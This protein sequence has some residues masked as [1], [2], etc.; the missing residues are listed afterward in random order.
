MI[1]K[2]LGKA[3]INLET[4]RWVVQNRAEEFLFNRRLLD[5]HPIIKEAKKQLK[6]LKCYPPPVRKVRKRQEYFEQKDAYTQAMDE[7]IKAVFD[8]MTQTAQTSPL[9]LRKYRDFDHKSDWR[10]C[11]Y[12]DHVY[13]FDRPDYLE[14]QMIEQIQHWEEKC[15]GNKKTL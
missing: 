15:A 11:L 6:T 5:R 7:A 1:I 2:K 9:P 12:K 13:L 3:K 14:D 10:Y 4:E 8:E